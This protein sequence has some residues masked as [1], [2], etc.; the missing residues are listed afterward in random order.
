M[1]QSA[2]IKICDAIRPLIGSRGV[3]RVSNF[4]QRKRRNSSDPPKPRLDGAAGRPI[5]LK[6]GTEFHSLQGA[7]A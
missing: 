3:L 5:R 6:D 1:K 2:R 4:A 7:D